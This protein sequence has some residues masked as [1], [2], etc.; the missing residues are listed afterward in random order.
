MEHNEVKNSQN[1][2]SLVIPCFNE[3]QSLLVLIPEI[4]KLAQNN[5]FEFI[6]V[7]NGSTDETNKLFSEI[8]QPNI[9][10]VALKNNAGYGGGI[11]FGLQHAT[12]EFIGW[13]H[14]DL[15]Y[16]LTKIVQNLNQQHTDIIYLK[17]F[18]CKRTIFQHFVS[19]CMS[20][21]ESLLFKHFI[22]DINAQPTVFHRTLYNRMIE[23]PNDF[24]IDLYS[25]VVAKQQKVK[26]RRFKID[27]EKRSHGESSWNSGLD[28]VVRM[29][30]KTVKYSITLRK[31]IVNY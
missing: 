3:Y 10:V 19:V 7:N 5:N 22:Y 1:R 20:I 30:I 13:V 21:F 12:N 31:N 9:R 25:Y 28:S 8:Y 4:I 18:R 17:G 14:A 16:S 15:Q 6:L 2:Y 26:I 24:S 29:S 11:K 27:F 23:M